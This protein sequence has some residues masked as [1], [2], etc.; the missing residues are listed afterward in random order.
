MS[1]PVVIILHGI[2]RT[3]WSMT[4]YAASLRLQGY[5]V[6]NMTYPS[7]RY[8]LKRI[9]EIVGGKIIKS[10]KIKEAPHIHFVTHSMGGLITRYIL[11][12]YPDIRAKTENVVMLV[13]PNGGSEMADFVHETGWMKPI[14]RFLYGPAGQQLTTTYASNYPAISGNIGIIAGTKSSNPL[15]RFVFNLGQKHDG[16]ISHDKMRL[17]GIDAVEEVAASH[18]SILCSPAAI[19]K[20]GLFIRS[21]KF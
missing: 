17:E 19:K 2:F 16:T 8:D 11:N 4:L 18:T 12:L 10:G 7:R 1:K 9:A 21:G 3:S 6:L 5:R 20:V 13:P 15:A 14:Y